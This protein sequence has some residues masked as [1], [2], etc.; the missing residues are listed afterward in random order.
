M[1]ELGPAQIISF[2]G[3]PSLWQGYPVSGTITSPYGPRVPFQTPQGMTSNH[4]D[5]IDIATQYGTPIHAPAPAEVWYSGLDLSGAQLIVLRYADGSG[6]LFAHMEGVQAAQGAHL[7]R[8]EVL[9][10]IGTSGLS[11]GPHLHYMRLSAVRPGNYWYAREETIDPCAPESGHVEV[12]SG[13][14][15]LWQPRDVAFGAWP[16]AGKGG[17]VVTTDECTADEIAA[18]AADEGCAVAALWMIDWTGNWVAYI[19]GAPAAVNAGF[20]AF[21][22]KWTTLFVRAA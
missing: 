11:T 19:V 5:G 1:P 21:V 3:I 6:S 10:Y 22:P 7:D 2:G 17:L 12:L 14:D 16:R 15:A 4:H 8:G 18:D 20:P 13:L 9:G